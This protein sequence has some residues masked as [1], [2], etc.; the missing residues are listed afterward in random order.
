MADMLKERIS[1]DLPPFTNVGVDYYGPIEVKRGC[2]M[3]KSYGVIFTCMASRAVHLEVAYS[4]DSYIN[5]LRRF[6]CCRGQ[7]RCLRSDNGTNFVGAEREL[8]EALAAID[9]SKIQS[10]LLH[11]CN[12]WTFNPPA[13]S[14]HG[15]VWE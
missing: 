15:D 9:H 2:A 12:D 14:H 4:A 11:K 10:A 5:A 1:P 13:A 3:A 6:V 8:G 7:V